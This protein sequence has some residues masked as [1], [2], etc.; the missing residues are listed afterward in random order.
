MPNTFKAKLGQ[1]E[2]L[3]M[4]NVT[5]TNQCPKDAAETGI[6]LTVSVRKAHF[7]ITTH[8]LINKQ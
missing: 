2:R 7:H 6:M 4:P 8:A 3:N 1:K 5:M